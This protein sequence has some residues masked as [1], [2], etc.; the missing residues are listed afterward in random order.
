MQ[1]P[2]R[3]A[4]GLAVAVATLT[5]G[6]VVSGPAMGVASQAVPAGATEYP[7][8]CADAN[9]LGT[10]SVGAASRGPGEDRPTSRRDHLHDFTEDW[11]GSEPLY[12]SGSTVVPDAASARVVYREVSTATGRA[13]KP[14]VPVKSANRTTFVE[15]EGAV[16][17]PSHALISVV[18]SSQPYADPSL[19]ISAALLKAHRLARTT[20]AVVNL[21]PIEAATWRGAARIIVNW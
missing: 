7:S 20:G 18:T 14:M 19:N 11:V 5:T 15:R 13:W 16:R 2:S 6:L 12:E 9:A 4:R 10:R 1:R 21:S 8:A 17:I 3:L